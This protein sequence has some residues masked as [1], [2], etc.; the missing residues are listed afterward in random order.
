MTASGG[1]FQQESLDGRYLYFVDR[2]NGV[3]G[4]S[5][6]V[7]VMRMPVEGG[8]AVKILDGIRGVFWSVTQKGIYFLTRDSHADSIQLYR[9]ADAKTVPIGSLP[10]RISGF[11]GGLVV[12]EDDRWLL[13]NQTNRNDTD[14]M[15]IDGFK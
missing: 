8:D 6:M 9:F 12:S 10:F 4:I 14:L 7:A 3:V 11:G 1:F 5:D 2:P 13:V 15:L